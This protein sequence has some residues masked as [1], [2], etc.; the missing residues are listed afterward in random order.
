[1]RVGKNLAVTNHAIVRLA[2]RMRV[3]GKDIEVVVNKAWFSKQ[4]ICEEFWK[5]KFNLKN[6]GCTTYH[7]R[8]FNRHLF[9]FQKKYFDF[10]LLTVFPESSEFYETYPKKIIKRDPCGSIL[11]DMYQSKNKPMRRTDNSRTRNNICREAS[12]REMGNPPSLRETSRRKQL[13][14]P[15]RFRQEISRMDGIEEALQFE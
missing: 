4:P 2:E 8:K 15:W 3:T 13:S 12:E 9:C 7:Y 10:V 1:M 6:I 5:S 14:R 11:Q